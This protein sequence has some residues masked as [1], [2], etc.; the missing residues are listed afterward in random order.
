MNFL[1]D[2]EQ[3]IKEVLKQEGYEEEVSLKPNSK[4]ELGEYQYNGIMSLA[5]KHGQ[6]PLEVAK[7]IASKLQ[8]INSFENVNVAGPGFLNITF[9]TSSLL[10]Y[11]NQKQKEE[12]VQKLPSKKIVI[13]YGG[14]NVAKVLHVGHL[15]SANIGESLKRLAKCL[16]MEV[17]SDIHLGDYGLQMGMIMLEIQNRYPNLPCFEENFQGKT[18]PDFKITNEDLI[19]LYPIASKKAKENEEVMQQARN[20][21]YLFQNNHP[22][23]KALWHAIIKVSLKDM[24][25]L[26]QRLC[27]DFDLWK[28]ES[29]A[30]VFIP[31]MIEYL[32]QK[33]LIKESEGAQIIEVSNPEDK[34]SIPPLLLIKSNQT[35]SYETTDLATIWEREKSLHPDEIWYVADKRQELHF[36][37]VFRAAKKSQIV[38][39]DTKLEFIGFGTMN[40]IDGKPF[41]TREGGVMSLRNLLNI[42]KTSTEKNM[43]PSITGEERLKL[44][45]I[46]AV[47]TIKF[48]DLL[49]HRNTDY[50]FDIDKFS[51]VNGKT[52]PFILY[53]TIR[54]KSLLEKAKEESNQELQFKKL[55]GK[56][57][58]RVLLETLKLQ[59]VLESAFEQ[60][61]L[62]EITNYLY[63]LD[64]TYNNF[65]AENRILTEPDEE[66]KQTWI[67][68]T[69]YIYQ[70]NLLLLDILAIPIPPRM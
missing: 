26:Y 4:P 57:D 12:L 21:T 18:I 49:S 14:P 69:K 8:K 27:V 51:D 1:T 10:E 5:K 34:V 40:G 31:E 53:S 25:E 16:G 47:G 22:G 65:Y 15:R 52:G 33:Q 23:Y 66:L 37:Q 17:I 59:S 41:K 32:K 7:N 3:I 38:K 36:T 64:N 60:K 30:E 42:V 70:I 48:A 63:L 9:S 58:K 68:M 43:I 13:D 55:K 67:A 50:I 44:A 46:I 61:S 39:E 29:D 2:Q 11:L 6:N 28:G 62:H 35:V 19:D 24:K 45:D 56:S 54:M 20:I